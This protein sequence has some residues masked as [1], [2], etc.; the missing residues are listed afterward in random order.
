MKKEINALQSLAL[1]VGGH[2]SLNLARAD[3]EKHVGVLTGH[4]GRYRVSCFLAF[5]YKSM[6]GNQKF[7]SP[8]ICRLPKVATDA[9]FAAEL[10]QV[11]A[12]VSAPAS[13][14]KSVN[15]FSLSLLSAYRWQPVALN[16]PKLELC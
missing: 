11:S 5:S 14:S 15:M 2:T 10:K 3:V 16:E 4:F 9:E 1:D 8:C 13:S 12:S 6:I 7:A